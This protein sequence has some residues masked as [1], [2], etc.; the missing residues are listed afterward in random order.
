LVVIAIIGILSAVI[1]ASLNTARSKGSDAAIESNLKTTQ[2]QAALDYSGN[3][4]S[5]GSTTWA[6]NSSTFTIASGTPGASA[7]F[8]DSVV[9]N[10]LSQ[11]ATASGALSYGSNATSF[12]IVA[13]LSTGSYWC[14]DGNGVS[15]QEPSANAP[16]G[17]NNYISGS[18]FACL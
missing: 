5:Y 15:K 8:S 2:T 17:T 11:A 16:T 3:G 4:N 9:G 14:V 6:A 7:L 1:L 10:A 12:V 13:K 18:N